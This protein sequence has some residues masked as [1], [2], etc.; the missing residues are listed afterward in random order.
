MKELLKKILKVSLVVAT[1]VFIIL[2]VKPSLAPFFI[3]KGIEGFEKN[4]FNESLFYL[5]IASFLNPNEPVIHLKLAQIYHNKRL[6]YRAIQEYKKSLKL[7]EK[8]S[9]SSLGLANTYIEIGQ[10]DEAILALNKALGFNPD[11]QKIKDL[12]ELA[13]YD[14]TQYQINRAANAYTKKQQDEAREFLKSASE[15]KP[16]F[17]FNLFVVENILTKNDSENKGIAA[18][19]RIAKMDPDYRVAYRLLGDSWLENLEYKKAI[20]AYEKYLAIEPNDAAIHNNLAVCYHRLGLLDK[21]IEQYRIALSLLP[22]NIN[23]IYGLASSYRHKDMHEEAINL[24]DHLLKLDP[25]L[26]Y[27]YVELAEIY[28]NTEKLNEAKEKLEEAIDIATK[29]LQKDP[30]DK[31]SK[32]ILDKTTASLEE[33]SDS[34]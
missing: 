14:Y 24:Y 6:F 12:A 3:N 34:D 5:K 1:T 2:Q 26:P 25:S 32:I 23:V 15:L 19:E 27:A 28:K 22:D 8:F 13:K 4:N 18:L 11:D 17:L 7:N 16:N 20:D 31:I 29:N 30:A 10:H 9:D 21:S 33:I